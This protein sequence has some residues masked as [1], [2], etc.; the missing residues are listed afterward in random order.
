MGKR[1]GYTT[2]TYAAA[3]A[4]AALSTLLNGKDLRKIE[5]ILPRGEKALIPVNSIERSGDS[6]RCGVVKK[7]VDRTDVTHN[8]EVFAQVSFREDDR[9]VIDGGAGIGR[10]TK[11]GLQ[12]PIGEAAINPVPREMIR[13]SLRELTF[14]GVDVVITAPK[15]EDLAAATHNPRLGITGGISII[16]T[17]GIM[18]PKSLASFK[19]TILQQLNLCRENGVKEV[20]ITPGNISEEAILRHF[21]DRVRKDEIVQ[22]GD[23]LGFTLRHAHRMTLRFILAGH[24]GKLAKVMGGYFQTHYSKSPQAN[25]FILQFL[26][27]KVGDAL[28]REMRESPT[29]EGVTSILQRHYR[30]ELLCGIAGAIEERVKRY[31]K[32][33][34]P[35]PVLLFNMNKEL[36]GFSKKGSEWVKR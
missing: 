31:L 7:S 30:G 2:G 4:K 23:F 10:V 1:F 20:V 5:I 22:S 28:L 17:T 9:I 26:E 18:R 13:C 27:G 24:P 6:V 36:I 29:V 3:A 25:D 33:T 8:L 12:I 11:K 21:G 19:S 32:T 34:S 14:R 15:G 35:I 16:G